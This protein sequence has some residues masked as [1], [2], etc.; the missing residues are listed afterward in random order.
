MLF[1]FLYTMECLFYF[2]RYL[3]YNFMWRVVGDMLGRRA[4]VVYGML[5]DS[6]L[7]V[8]EDVT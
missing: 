1:G 5:L 8:G 4:V 7:S 6:L 2:R 3:Q